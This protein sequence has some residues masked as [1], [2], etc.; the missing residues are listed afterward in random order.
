M[1]S[2]TVADHADNQ[3]T[4]APTVGDL[5]VLWQHP[6]SRQIIP[7]GRFG[8]NGT[9]YSFTYTRAAESIEG[10]RSLPGLPIGQRYESSRLPAAFEQRVMDPER[11]DFTAYVASLGLNSSIAT[12]WE[13][14]VQSGGNR[15]GD[16]LQ[17]MEVP[18]VTHGRAR[19]R[20]LANGV[21]HIP[22]EERIVDGR[23]VVVTATQQE[24]ALQRLGP[25]QVLTLAPED[26]NRVD[27]SAT[28]I[29]SDGTPIGWVPRPLSASIRE[30]MEARPVAVRVVRVGEKDTP[31]H[32]RLVLDMDVEAPPAFE[33]D[34]DRQWEPASLQ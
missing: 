15:A 16:T 21:R 13:Q 22:G 3:S 4:G 34:R 1:S 14:I 27:P 32:F 18:T 20:F 25:G 33:F 9:T 26:A 23:I 29:T 5:L 2:A 19:A 8:F 11:P 6:E 17:F 30:L 10:F 24:T 7:V 31:P 12:P 28:L